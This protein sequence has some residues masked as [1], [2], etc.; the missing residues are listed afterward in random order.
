MQALVGG[1]LRKFS[2]LG[3]AEFGAVLVLEVRHLA[4][5]RVSASLLLLKRDTNLRCPLLEFDRIAT[6][7]RSDVDELLRYFDVAIV[8]DANLSDDIDRLTLANRFILD[9]DGRSHVFP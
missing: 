4:P 2:V 3:L 5:R 7:V 9:L 8:I 6:C 1:V